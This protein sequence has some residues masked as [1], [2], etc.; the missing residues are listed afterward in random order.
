[1]RLPAGQ[2]LGDAKVDELDVRPGW[3]AIGPRVLG[4]QDVA[5]LEV[6]MHHQPPVCVLHRAAHL[7]E[8]LEAA[9]DIETVAV[10]VLEQRH[11]FD[12]LHHQVRPTLRGDAAVE[13][14]FVVFEEALRRRHGR[15]CHL[16]RH[17]AFQGIEVRSGGVLLVE[18]RAQQP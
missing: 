8:Q 7:L 17:V 12:Q 13:R 6:A 2:D 4:D 9:V 1:M 16:A 18:R 3:P 10:A 14:Q 15:P 5:G 11:A